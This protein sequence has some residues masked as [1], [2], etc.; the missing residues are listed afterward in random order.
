[1][2]VWEWESF[3][4]FINGCLCTIT[5]PGPLCHPVLNF[6]VTRDK[7]LQ[8][9]LETTGAHGASFPR[10]IGPPAGTVCYNNELVKIAH[11][12][13]TEIIVKG[14][15]LSAWKIY[16]DEM[17]QPLLKE[18]SSFGSL[19]AVLKT[20]E[21]AKYTIEWLAN[22]DDNYY[23]WPD[24]LK[25]KLETT[26]SRTFCF[27]KNGTTL[28]SSNESFSYRGCLRVCINGLEVFLC[29]NPSSP[30][31]EKDPIKRG[32]LL[33]V[34]TPSEEIREKIR[35]CL[36]FSLG[37]YFVYLGCSI[38]SQNGQL[39]SFKAVRGYSIDNKVFDKFMGPPAYIGL[40]G[41]KDIDAKQVSQIV[42]AL[43]A[44]YDP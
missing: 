7:N 8:L 5:N 32:F 18:T 42:N 17:G 34:G 10:A 1:M 33:Y 29:P 38:F 35:N 11:P 24:T 6:S 14:V 27:G 2:A 4:S 36:S 39:T 43:Y 26:E 15:S 25:D 9:I 16:S 37:M 19:E 12:S 20:S 22:V 23:I 21:E 44:E 13:G 30:T 41:A 31:E 3:E 40:S 28:N